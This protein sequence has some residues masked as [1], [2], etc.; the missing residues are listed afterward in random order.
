MK[1]EKLDV[2]GF[3]YGPKGEKK[4]RFVFIAIDDPVFGEIELSQAWN[5]LNY[6]GYFVFLDH[7][8]RNIVLARPLM[9]KERLKLRD[10]ELAIA[11]L[12]PNDPP[13]F[14][15]G[16]ATVFSGSRPPQEICKSAEQLRNIPHSTK[17]K[18]EPG[19]AN[20]R[21][22]TAGAQINLCQD[23]HFEIAG[24][25]LRVVIEAQPNDVE[26]PVTMARILIKG[27]TPG[28][29][30][31]DLGLDDP[32]LD[33]LDN[34]L[35]YFS[36]SS[37]TCRF[38]VFCTLP[39]DGTKREP[40]KFVGHAD[41]LPTVPLSQQPAVL[42]FAP[43]S[44][45]VGSNFTTTAG[46]R[47]TLRP[48]ADAGLKMAP[49]TDIAPNS[50]YLQP[51]GSFEIMPETAA[52]KPKLVCGVSG[53]EYLSFTPGQLLTFVPDMAATVVDEKLT[54][55]SGTTSWIGLP[56]FD[57]E[58]FAQPQNGEMYGDGTGTS[59]NFTDVPLSKIKDI[60]A[61]PMVPFRGVS[62]ADIK[63]A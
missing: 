37:P 51:V 14:I 26:I 25:S 3:V 42:T 24:K 58:Y 39:F 13:E 12:R 60:P 41:L 19:F 15:Y 5:A 10:G 50:T 53:S 57:A 54:T 23:D 45:P 21:L 17:I 18:A 6:R 43:G 30:E 56:Q 33:A 48:A 29:I 55:G 62:S 11:W 4:P 35:R 16:I 20:A 38:P 46:S 32:A 7:W 61:F 59:R 47:I 40:V 44:G 49:R 8:D 36:A 2:L 22:K 9:F 27:P 28:L 63:R 52:G 34:G 31:F 1:L